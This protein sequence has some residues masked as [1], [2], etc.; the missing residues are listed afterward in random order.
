MSLTID[1][2]KPYLENMV[3]NALAV[4]VA[5][6]VDIGPMATWNMHQQQQGNACHQHLQ[7]LHGLAAMADWEKSK[8]A[9]EP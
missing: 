6:V 5:V 2:G 1:S 7:N 8:G 3:R 4:A 9:R